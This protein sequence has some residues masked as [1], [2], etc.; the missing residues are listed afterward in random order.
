MEP[1]VTKKR[2]SWDPKQMVAAVNAVRRKVMGLKKAAMS[3]NV[4]RS[5]L[6]I[7]LRN[8]NMM[9]KR[10]CWEIWA[11]SR[12]CPLNWRMNLYSSV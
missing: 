8:V 6:K 2:K 9:S 10:E 7:M 5:T 11:E 12:Y 3:F 4:P 1:T